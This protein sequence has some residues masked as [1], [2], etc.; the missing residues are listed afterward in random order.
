[1]IFIRKWAIAI[2]S[3]LLVFLGIFLT[4]RKSGADAEK[5]KSTNKARETE[6][7]AVDALTT[8][9][10]NEVAALEEARR[11]RAARKRDGLRDRTREP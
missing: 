7:K 1:M 10:A 3:A 6:H 11:R 5:V 9:L 4:G 2:G 8:G